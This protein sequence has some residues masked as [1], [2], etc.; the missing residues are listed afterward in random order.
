MLLPAMFLAIC[1]LIND[2]K[3]SIVWNPDDYSC[4]QISRSGW[5]QTMYMRSVTF[6]GKFTSGSLI[7]ASRSDLLKLP[8]NEPATVDTFK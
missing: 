4:N 2:G 5:M 6:L 1:C 7:S 8:I 3:L